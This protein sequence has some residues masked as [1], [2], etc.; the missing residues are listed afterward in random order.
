MQTHNKTL[1]ENALKIDYSKKGDVALT[2][3]NTLRKLV[4]ILG[5]AL[6]VLLLAFL[7]IDSGYHCPLD[8]MSH[9]YYSR[10]CSILVV[11]LSL[12][13]IFLLIYKGDG[14]KDF[15]ISSIAGLFAFCVVFFPTSNIGTICPGIDRKYIV[16]TIL[17]ACNFRE[18]FHLISAAIFLT[19][20]AYMSYFLFPKKDDD[21]KSKD[22]ALLKNAWV[23]RLCAIVMSLALI[24]M[25]AHFAFKFIDAETYDAN[26]LTFWME[27][28]A[29]ESFGISWLVKGRTGAKRSLRHQ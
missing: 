15:F 25:L 27:S 13:A 21:D 29:V 11:V 24:V 18:T 6:P 23:F 10:V 20:L 22:G 14:S 9:Y 28:V 16:V 17:K 2:D 19:C 5:M 3:Q 12:M 8:S 7:Y 26:H 1:L 4:G